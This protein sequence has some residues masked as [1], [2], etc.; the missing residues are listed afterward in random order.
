MKSAFGQRYQLPGGKLG[1]GI[2]A[3]DDLVFRH[4]FLQ[5]RCG[6]LAGVR[7]SSCEGNQRV[8]RWHERARAEKQEGKDTTK[9]FLQPQQ[10]GLNLAVTGTPDA[11]LLVM[12]LTVEPPESF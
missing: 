6:G 1:L 11:D 4:V 9:S 3:G 12:T 5:R 8:R 7:E 10:T 2:T